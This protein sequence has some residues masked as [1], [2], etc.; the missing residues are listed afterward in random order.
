MNY[1][2]PIEPGQTA[3]MESPI[4]PGRSS[5]YILMDPKYLYPQPKKPSEGLYA[6]ADEKETPG[7]FGLEQLMAQQ[8][9]ILNS[10]IDMLNTHIHERYK[11]K[12]QN[13]YLIDRD[14]CVCRNLIYTLGDHLFHPKRI[15]LEKTILDLEQ[16]KRREQ[17]VFFQD[18][19]FLRKE[20]R[21]TEIQRIE[22][23]QKRRFFIDETEAPACKV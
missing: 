16:E 12:S 8:D 21:E 18:I 17:T 9:E 3:V 22:Q 15:D 1:S 13:L 11:L 20:L 10:K 5:Q 14:Q 6:K 19:L 2:Y 4:V 7:E 23:E